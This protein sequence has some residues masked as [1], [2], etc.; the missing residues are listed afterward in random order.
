MKRNH[1]ARLF[2]PQGTP[3]L[4]GGCMETIPSTAAEGSSHRTALA[5]LA[6]TSE[7]QIAH[8]MPQFCPPIQLPHSTTKHP[9]TQTLACHSK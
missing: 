5:L 4:C 2:P 6:D 9:W 7:L 1:K 8:I 3:A